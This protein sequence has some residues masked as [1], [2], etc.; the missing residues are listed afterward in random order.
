MATRL[1]FIRH[2]RHKTDPSVHQIEWVLNAEGEEQ[3]RGIARNAEL[4]L[5]DILCASEETKA[6][7]TL[8]PLA[9]KLGKDIVISSAFNEVWR[10]KNFLTDEE[11]AL[12]KKRQL[13]DLDCHA[14]NGES[15]NEALARMKAGVDLLC[16]Q[17]PNKTIIIA[18]HGTILSIY[19]ADVL[20]VL[21]ELP[22][23]WQKTA[24]GAYGIIED[25]KVIKDIVT[26]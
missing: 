5:A 20:G 16:K 3:A 26:E 11:F 17:Y 4:A 25:G 6:R 12:E 19:F 1:I 9:E 14:F 10:E 23:R 18:T 22:K 8:A 2:A 21:D 15:G 24:F 7:L 13:A